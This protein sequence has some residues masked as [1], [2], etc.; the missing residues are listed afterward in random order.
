MAKNCNFFF[1]LSF[2]FFF[3]FENSIKLSVGAES[4]IFTH[5]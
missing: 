2:F 1:F 5:C 3:F 4:E